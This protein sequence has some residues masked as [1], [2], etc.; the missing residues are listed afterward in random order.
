MIYEPSKKLKNS[1]IQVTESYWEEIIVNKH[2]NGI[3]LHKDG[4]I[5]DVLSQP[6]LMITELTDVYN[7]TILFYKQTSGYLFHLKQW[8]CVI[9]TDS[10]VKNSGSKATSIL[11][12]LIFFKFFFC[13]Y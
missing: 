9:T 6:T 8:I 3:S 13:Y 7:I 11:N 4:V 1:M 10:T 5:L 12:R 2:L